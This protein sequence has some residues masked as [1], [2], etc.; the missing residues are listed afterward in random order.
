MSPTGDRHAIIVNRDT[1]RDYELY[2]ATPNWSGLH[3]HAYA[4]AIFNLR[5]DRLR[6]AG[7]TSAD[8]AGLPILPGLVRYDEVARGVI[9]HALRFT[10]PA[11]RA[12]FAYPARHFACA[13][14]ARTCR[15]WVSACA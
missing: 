12:A 14:A 1:C 10:A 5:S 6:P 4:G 9:D 15:R 8:G 11:T 7:W 13:R 2:N 3:W